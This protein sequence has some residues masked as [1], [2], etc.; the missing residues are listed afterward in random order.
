MATYDSR[1]D[2]RSDRMSG[3]A[4]TAAPRESNPP[5]MAAAAL[6]LVVGAWLAWKS[7]LSTAATRRPPGLRTPLT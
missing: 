7:A 3:P 1:V 5:A 2:N 4:D 6:N